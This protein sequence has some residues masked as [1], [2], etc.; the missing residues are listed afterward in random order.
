MET[1][2]KKRI[3]I[4]DCGQPAHVADGILQLLEPAYQIELTNDYD[5]DYVIHSCMGYEVLKYSGIR[6]FV[7]G[8]CV[9]PNFNIS[10]Y[11]LAFD[12]MA[13]GDRNHWFPLIKLYT[14]AYTVLNSPR[15]PADTVIQQKS[16]FC[17][18]VMSN[19]KNSSNERIEIFDLLNAYKTV[20]S[21]GR[22]RNNVGGPVADKLDFQSRHKFV[23]AFE[24][25]S[26]PGYLT[27]KFAEAAQSGAI[28]IYWGDPEIGNYFNSKAFINCHDYP[29]LDAAVSRVIEIDQNDALY[30]T[31]LAE[32]WFPDNSEPG[33][34]SAD[35]I[36][37]FLKNIFDQPC[38]AAYRRN[39][40]RWGMKYEKS[41][42]RMYCAPLQQILH[43]LRAR[44]RGKQTL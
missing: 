16:G 40:S 13:F 25:N 34:L 15:A 19:T 4:V 10:D 24:N 8:E 3:A 14:D 17:A 7:C 27:E 32:P 6:I 26:H 29:T 5:A 20:S 1:K 30:R 9:S 38:E 36:K 12:R 33:I 44:I 22:W 28:P 39:R 41:L 43:Q 35:S 11:A 21:G 31:M 42:Y 37:S 23:I 2:A 18:Y